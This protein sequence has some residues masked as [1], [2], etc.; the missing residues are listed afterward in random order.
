MGSTAFEEQRPVGHPIVLPRQAPFRTYAKRGRR[1]GSVLI[2][3]RLHRTVVD[4]VSAL[5]FS[6]GST[7]S[8]PKATESGGE[9]PGTIGV[10]A[11]G[12]C[13][14]AAQCMG[15]CLVHLMH[16]IV[17]V[18]GS[19]AEGWRGPV[20]PNRRAQPYPTGKRKVGG[21]GRECLQK[22]HQ[23]QCGVDR[24]VEWEDNV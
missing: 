7:L 16:P 11:M 22:Q 6:T 18:A 17:P 19:P 3:T 10:E 15:H 20:L 2:L 13:Q 14:D 5:W 21:E 1:S 12:H 9:L 4:P 24:N 8:P 23:Q